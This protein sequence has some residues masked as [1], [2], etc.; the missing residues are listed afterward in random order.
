MFGFYDLD[1]LTALFSGA[2]VVCNTVGPFHYFGHLVVEACAKA[3]VH[4][5]DTTGEIPFMHEA[6]KSFGDQYEANG[7][8]LAPCTSY[9]YTP[10]EIAAH[11]ALETPGVDTLEA[12]CSATGTPTYGS[13][14]TIFA[15]FQT[16]DQAFYLENR[17]RTIWPAA[18]V[19]RCGAAMVKR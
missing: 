2:Q 17:Q 19:S 5:L 8:V 15:M 9:M 1:A 14:Q 7:K 4:Y 16:S 10:L 12:I 18:I 11:I 13:T 6:S 3:N